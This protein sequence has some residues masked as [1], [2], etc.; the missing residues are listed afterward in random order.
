MHAIIREIL[1]RAGLLAVLDARAAGRVDLV[2]VPAATFDRTDLLALGALADLLRAREV[3]DTVT[4]TWGRP[5]DPAAL[6][7][8]GEPGLALLRAAAR[9][10]ILGPIGARIHVDVPTVGF[11]LAQ[12]ALAFGAD[13]LVGPPVDRRGLPL[14]DGTVRV[15]GEGPVSLATMKEREI[16]RIL[17][18][19]GRVAVFERGADATDPT[20][21]RQ[22]SHAV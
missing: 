14:A 8:R 3:G 5:C 19:A 2:R 11:E 12:V 20:V 6:V 13:A 10:R 4:V 22:E 7:V 17:E 9:A 16:R 15:K 1:D 18:A 21:L